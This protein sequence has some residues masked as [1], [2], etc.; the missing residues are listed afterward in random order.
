MGHSERKRDAI[1]VAARPLRELQRSEI[2]Q[3]GA[4]QRALRRA[5]KQHERAL[6][7]AQH[8]LQAARTARPLAAYGRRLILYEDCLST[9]DRNHLLT[10]EVTATVEERAAHGR[11]PR[12]VALVVAG[13]RWSEAVEGP[14]ADERRL[15]SLAERIE[16]AAS[17][18]ADVGRE[19]GAEGEDAELAVATAEA[20]RRAIDEVGALVH[21]LGDV[22]G[23]GEDVLDM[24]P[25]ISA[26]HDG[27][28]VATDER[29]LFI[30][31]RRSLTLSYA[32]ISSVTVKGRWRW[33]RLTAATPSGKARFSGLAPHHAAAL[34]ELIRQ[35]SGLDPASV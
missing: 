25:A 28:L 27:V 14:V 1:E 18:A 34:A 21:R 10:A 30:G 32:S 19:R 17:A 16:A 5:D 24:G 8:D 23:E 2:K 29:L 33:S 12:G 11:G 22:L 9:P 35:R 15:R 6:R 20:D 4:A 26:G 3:I 31:L 7:Q 13:D